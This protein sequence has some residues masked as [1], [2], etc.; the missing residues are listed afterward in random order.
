M[1]FETGNVGTSGDGFKTKSTRFVVGFGLVIDLAKDLPREFDE[2]MMGPAGGKGYRIEG[3]VV[4][5]LG[6]LDAAAAPAVGEKVRVVV[7]PGDT[8]KAI[9]D[10]L[11]KTKEGVRFLLEGV[12]GNAD[13]LVARWA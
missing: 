4:S 3:Q 13:A 12:T 11:E 6:A 2:S 9:F 1:A 10:D 5:V 8:C 7:R